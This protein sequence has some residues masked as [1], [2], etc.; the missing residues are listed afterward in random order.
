MSGIC[1]EYLNS[2]AMIWILLIFLSMAEAD[3]GYCGFIADMGDVDTT[4]KMHF[5]RIKE[6]EKERKLIEGTASLNNVPTDAV[7]GEVSPSETDESGR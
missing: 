5:G 6:I 2:R 7:L 1:Q 4:R 3:G